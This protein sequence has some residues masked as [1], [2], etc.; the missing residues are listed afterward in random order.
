MDDFQKFIGNLKKQQAETER[1]LEGL[2]VERQ[3]FLQKELET[4]VQV[5][6]LLNA[7]MR[8][9]EAK[10]KPAT[11]VLGEIQFALDNLKNVWEYK[12][13]SG[14]VGKPKDETDSVYY[15]TK[16]GISLRLKKIN[17]PKGIRHVVQPFME[18]VFFLGDNGE[19]V[20]KPVEGYVVDEYLSTDFLRLQNGEIPV[21][22]DFQSNIAKYMHGQRIIAVKDLQNSHLQ[23]DGSPV[24]NIIKI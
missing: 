21:K 7:L 17:L 23:H 22:G 18:Q 8:R 13:R 14:N 6:D 11:E 15:M 4:V 19:I 12:F 20:E 5:Q 9:S 2:P 1:V 10:Q 3:V 24:N 16:S